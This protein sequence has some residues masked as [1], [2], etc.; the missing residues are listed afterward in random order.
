MM[1]LAK[2]GTVHSAFAAARSGIVWTTA[3]SEYEMQQ[4]GETAAV[5]AMAPFASGL[6]GL[7]RPTTTGFDAEQFQQAYEDFVAEAGK[8]P[9][10]LR[11]VQ[12]K[13][14]YASQ[15]TTVDWQLTGQDPAKPWKRNVEVTVT[16]AFPFNTPLI[17]RLMGSRRDGWYFYDIQS[18]IALQD[19]APQNEELNTG[20][21][22]A[23]P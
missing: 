15:A 11:Y 12:A 21:R 6:M 22:Y 7:R 18:T 13:Y 23:S 9:S 17:G 3:G 8:S 1:L 19:E 14:G 20:I 10:A 4:R 5:R 2:I 16:Y